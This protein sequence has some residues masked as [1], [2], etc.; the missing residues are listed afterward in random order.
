M[1]LLHIGFDIAVLVAEEFHHHIHSIYVD[2][3]I[4]VVAPEKN[5]EELLQSALME[6]TK[7]HSHQFLIEPFLLTQSCYVESKKIQVKRDSTPVGDY[8]GHIQKPYKTPPTPRARPPNDRALF[9]YLLSVYLS[10]GSEQSV[11]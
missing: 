8:V 11:C 3:Q 4:V 9:Y 1:R 5:K 2:P 10:A 7:K 6:Y